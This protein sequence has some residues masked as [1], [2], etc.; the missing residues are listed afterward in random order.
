MTTAVTAPVSNGLLHGLS[1]AFNTG[2]KHKLEAGAIIEEA[3]AVHVTLSL[4]SS[5]S[6]STQIAALRSLLQ[7]G[8]EGALGKSFEKV[9]KASSNNCTIT[10]PFFCLL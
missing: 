8:G 4:G 1:T 10:R 5:N 7:G 2:A 6:V 9:V 3:A